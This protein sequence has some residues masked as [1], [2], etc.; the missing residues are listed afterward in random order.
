MIFASPLTKPPRLQF[1][2][3]FNSL[4]QFLQGFAILQTPLE[5]NTFAKRLKKIAT[6]EYSVVGNACP[7]F[8]ILP[9]HIFADQMGLV[10]HAESI[11]DKL[12]ILTPR[13]I[14][15]LAKMRQNC[16]NGLPRHAPIAKDY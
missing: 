13:Q 9:V 12:A 1:E 16:F 5:T 3:I 4:L 14:N 7:C 15:P 11:G 10:T 6:A 2:V 8:T